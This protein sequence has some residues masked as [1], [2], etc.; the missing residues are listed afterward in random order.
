M[1]FNIYIYQ[2][3]YLYILTIDSVRMLAVLFMQCLITHRVLLG[4]II[5]KAQIGFPCWSMSIHTNSVHIG[6]LVSD[7]K[8]NEL[9]SS[10]N[11]TLT[12]CSRNTFFLKI[13]FKKFPIVR[14]AKY[15]LF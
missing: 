12:P 3:A 9:L 1:V 2:Q 5:I 6:K 7:S 11:A 15:A 8:M 4:P 10:A 14:V 13:N